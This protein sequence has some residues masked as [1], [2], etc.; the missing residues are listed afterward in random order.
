MINI[1]QHNYESFF[2]LYIDG[3]LSAQD[4]LAVESFVQLHP[5]LGEEL[6]MLQQVQL[7]DESLVYTDKQTLF[8]SEAEEIHTGNYEDYFLLYVDN[9]LTSDDRVKLETYVLQHPELQPAFT[10]LT[11]TRLEPETLVFADKALL[12]RK[13][14][15]KPVV[16]YLRWQA[17]GIAAS[18][19]GFA[20][21]LW[22]QFADKRTNILLPSAARLEKINTPP[23]QEQTPSRENTVT[24]SVDKPD[25]TQA[26]TKPGG[27]KVANKEAPQ[28]TI[29]DRPLANT[30]DNTAADISFPIQTDIHSIQ[31]TEIISGSYDRQDIAK[32][33]VQKIS[34]SNHPIAAIESNLTETNENVS[35]P[36]EALAQEIVYKEIDISSDEARKTLLLGSLELNKDK[37]RGFFRKAGNIFRSKTKLNEEAADSPASVDTRTLK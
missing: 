28:Q 23:V 21:L 2:L 31:K 32:A 24:A 1:N 17:M 8:R 33:P 37:L 29:T 6:A 10:L 11:Q 12:Y 15:K 9:E 35:N 34:L 36:K 7:I 3:E 16:F 20:F 5:D 18:L 14:E 30:T 4:R 22:T 26:V 13:E 25:N 19:I 27:N